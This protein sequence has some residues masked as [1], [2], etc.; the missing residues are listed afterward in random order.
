[1]K[2]PSAVIGPG[3]TIELANPENQTDYEAELAIVIGKKAKDVEPGDALGYI[4]GYTAAND[5]SDRNLQFGP[6]GQW[7]RAKG[8]DTYCPLGPVIATDIEPGSLKIGSKLNG[9]Q[10]QN[11]NTNDLIFDV[12]TLISFL[13][14]IMTLNPG[15]V[16]LTGTPEKVGGMK[17]GDVIE[18]EVEGIGSLTNPVA[19]R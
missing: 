18:V 2:P 3:E 10:R 14:K 15:D 19:A 5:V 9:E 6:G 8:F 11:S 16:I 12:P 1:M 13:S 4:F 7:I 17:P